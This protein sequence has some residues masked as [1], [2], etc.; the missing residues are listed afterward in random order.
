MEYIEITGKTVYEAI[1]N[2]TINLSVTIYNL[3]YEVV[4]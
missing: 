1:T 3:D 2:A 4:D